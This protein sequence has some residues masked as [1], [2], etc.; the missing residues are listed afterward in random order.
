MCKIHCSLKSSFFIFSIAG[1]LLFS[2]C[3]EEEENINAGLPENVEFNYLPTDLASMLEFGPIGQIRVVPKAHGGFRLK[4]FSQEANIPVYA[5]SDGIIYQIGKNKL[6]APPGFAPDELIGWEYDDYFVRIA[7]SK[8]ASMWYGHVSRLADEILD[9]SP[10][11]QT[12][13]G[14]GTEVKIEIKAGDI[15]GYIGPHPGFDI[16]LFDFAKPLQFLNKSIYG[17]Q[18]MHMQPWTDYLTPALRNQVWAINPRTVEPRGGKIN[19]DI[20][21]TL[22]GN[23]FLEGTTE[24][25]QWS[26]QLVFARHEIYADR[27]AIADASPLVDGDGSLNSDKS[28]FLWFVKGNNPKPEDINV[29][30]GFATYEVADWWQLLD[31]AS[32]APDGTVALQ[33]L[34]ANTLKY[35]FFPAKTSAQVTNFTSAAK[36]YKR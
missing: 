33:L 18:Y 3:S 14:M 21:G 12:G 16:G 17:E 29:S 31:N 15:I 36:V 32:A 23:W 27:I 24:I 28:S 2:N 19:Y 13:Y 6:T 1:L 7:I 11:L 4:T 9:Q 35:E 26:K 8:S 5:M 20:A 10:A 22:A 25:T 30:S 34:D